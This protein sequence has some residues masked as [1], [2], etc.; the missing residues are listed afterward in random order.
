[1]EGDRTSLT[2]RM[3]V[4]L[5]ALEGNFREIRRRVGEG[6]IIIA[7]IKADAYG[8]GAVEV[9]RTLV[10]LDIYALA[11]GS[12]DDAL[13]VRRSGN[14]ARILIFGNSPPDT[15]PEL[16]DHGLVPSVDSMDMARAVSETADAPSPVFIK[17]DCGFGRFGVP[18]ETAQTFVKGVAA[19]PNIQIEGV[20]THL[21]FP[22]AAGRDWAR[23]RHAV[24]DRLIADLAASGREIPITQ[25]IDSSGIAGG[26]TDGSNAIAPGSLLYGLAPVAPEVGDMSGFQPVLR[27]IRTRLIHVTE[28]A[29]DRPSHVDAE[30]L[31]H[32]VT[33]T[34]IVP[35]GINEGYRGTEPGRT[36]AMLLRGRRVPVL[37]VCLENTVLDLS[38]ID[39]PKPGEE[40]VAMGSGG[41]EEID[42]EEMAKWW[43]CSPL[44]AIMSFARRLP[45]RYAGGGTVPK[46]ATP[47]PMASRTHPQ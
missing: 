5:G 20:Y 26:L 9:A 40:V 31:R 46:P 34:G 24:F 14:Q 6:K 38:A 1:M 47:A 25:A 28:R 19:L 13:A 43:A 37:R 30:Y 8:H 35:L 7:S 16:L 3:E 11:T 36:A 22:D 15:V 4:D 18:V 32:G 12:L 23:K 41:E 27:A 42:L 33:A 21:P 10:A 39:R 44:S 2:T 17:V 45:H 29:A